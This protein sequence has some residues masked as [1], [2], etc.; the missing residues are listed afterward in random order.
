M[1]FDVKEVEPMARDKGKDKGMKKKKKKV[2][3][4]GA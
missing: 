3:K 1:E 4:K 2:E